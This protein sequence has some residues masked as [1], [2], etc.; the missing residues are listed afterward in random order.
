MKKTKRTRSAKPK[1]FAPWWRKPIPPF[2]VHQVLGKLAQELVDRANEIPGKD[3]R[4]R[5]LWLS[6]AREIRRL[7]PAKLVDYPLF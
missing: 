5:N 6:I 3:F 4:Q 2:E 7:E 1:K